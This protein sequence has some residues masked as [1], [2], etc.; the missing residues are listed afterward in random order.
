MS[1]IE[2][3]FGSR[4]QGRSP[5]IDKSKWNKDGFYVLPGFYL[6]CEIDAALSD[7]ENAWKESHSR[8]VVDDLVTGI[9]SRLSDVGEYEKANHEFKLNDLYLESSAIRGLA[10]NDRITPILN[11]LLGHKAVLCNSLNFDKGSSQPDHVDALYMTP[12]SVGHLIA[13]WVALE[14]CHVDAGPLRYYPGSHKIEPYIFS[15]GSRHVV[16]E[17][18]DSWQK[19]MN[20][21]ISRLSLC[22]EIFAAKKG[23][24]LIWSAYLLHGGSK[25]NDVNMTRKSVVFHY[26]S[27]RD[28]RDNNFD[29]VE[30]CGGYWMY[31]AHQP[32]NG[33]FGEMPPRP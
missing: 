6:G 15:N 33:E 29:L 17:E 7:A 19:Y 1:L 5:S 13:I 11:E 14:D 8:L 4:G 32:I 3:I 23:D 21:N 10:I 27:E 16:Y 2:R 22:P 25:I 18:M 12:K 26:Y 31:R 28:S 30:S 24:V 20:E 9:R